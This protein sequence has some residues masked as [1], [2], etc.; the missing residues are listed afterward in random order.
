MA[1]RL[2]GDWLSKNRR[3]LASEQL[4]R[5]AACS[6]ILLGDPAAALVVAS[7]VAAAFAPASGV[8]GLAFVGASGV[9]PADADFQPPDAP[10]AVAAGAFVRG[11]GVPAPV[12]V[13][14]FAAPAGAFAPTPHHE[15]FAE[16]GRGGSGWHGSAGFRLDYSP[17]A[18]CLAVPRA[19]GPRG[20][21]DS[22]EAGAPAEPVGLVPVCS[23]VRA[24]LA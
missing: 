4:F 2:R 7:P 21:A 23:A 24:D 12:V 6:T 18:S 5:C 14:A 1:S 19:A 10:F 16:A 11:A 17:E 15:R 9:P 8:L 20:Y 3:A 22:A 13:A